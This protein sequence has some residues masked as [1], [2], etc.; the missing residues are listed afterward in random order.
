MHHKHT[1]Y[2]LCPEC[3]PYA[4]EDWTSAEDKRNLNAIC[5]GGRFAN[6]LPMDKGYYIIRESDTV[7]LSYVFKMPTKARIFHM[8][9]Y[10]CC[11]NH[12]LKLVGPYEGIND[13][14]DGKVA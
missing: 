7:T 11:A 13:A 5:R 9:G 2:C 14:F 12:S 4:Y 10:G 3:Y 6:E 1:Q 8:P